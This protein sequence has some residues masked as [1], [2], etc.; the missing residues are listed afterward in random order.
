[1][2]YNF[3]QKLLT[4][5]VQAAVLVYHT[6]GHSGVAEYSF[7]AEPFLLYITGSEYFQD[8]LGCFTEFVYHKDAIEGERDFPGQDVV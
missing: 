8:L 4:F 5:L 2:F 7:I 6:V 3:F 1:M